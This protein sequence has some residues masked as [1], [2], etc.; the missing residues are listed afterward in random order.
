MKK[1]YKSLS[2]EQVQRY[3]FIGLLVLVFAAFFI[4][5][6]IANNYEKNKQDDPIE[7]PNDNNNNN[8]NNN[9][10]T[11]DDG[12][13]GQTPTPQKET[14]NMPIN[15]DFKVVRK[16]YDMEDSKEDQELSVI[17]FG[18]RYYTSNGVALSNS[19][20]T[21]FEVLA[22][23]SGEVVSVDESPIYGVVVTLKHENGL[24]TEYS[25]LSE[26][27]VAAGN[28]VKQ[29]DVIGVS[30]ICEYDSQLDSHVYFKVMTETK[31]YNP[32]DVIGQEVE[33]IL[34]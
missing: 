27:K 24:Y 31:N 32:E 28:T 11:P 26:A 5:L 19:E 16:F 2:K 22:S 7:E 34:K 9:N 12:N 20:K 10:E 3:V 4:S 15:G 17:Q 13:D 8:N 33:N 18:K 30:G 14:I 21:D 1:W 29:G 6:S 23:L 25:S